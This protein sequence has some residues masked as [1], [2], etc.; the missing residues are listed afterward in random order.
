MDGGLH[1]TRGPGP[2][3]KFFFFF[4]RRCP[5]DVFLHASVATMCTH[6]LLL[7]L[8]PVYRNRSLI[9]PPARASTAGRRSHSH[10]PPR[11][12]PAERVDAA[13]GFFR[14]S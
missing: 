10:H 4:E 12:G 5:V 2:E 7:Q 11:V 8:G 14:L 13:D 9:V 1:R 6:A 3:R